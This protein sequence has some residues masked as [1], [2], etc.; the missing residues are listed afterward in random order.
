[1]TKPRCVIHVR[2]SGDL[3]ALVDRAVE[4]DVAKSRSDFVR[5]AVAHSLMLLASDSSFSATSGL[6]V[7]E[8]E[9]SI[10]GELGVMGALGQALMR[11]DR[12]AAEAEKR[13]ARLFRRQGPTAFKG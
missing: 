3:V 1:M 12:K 11:V 8:V 10:A 13:F 5:G 2:L 7:H 9:N 4:R 6:G